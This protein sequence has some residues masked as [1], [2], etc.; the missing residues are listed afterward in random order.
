VETCRN[1]GSYKAAICLI[2]VKIRC[3]TCGR[4]RRCAAP[5]GTRLDAVD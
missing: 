4:C 3:V 5:T 1:E 2:D